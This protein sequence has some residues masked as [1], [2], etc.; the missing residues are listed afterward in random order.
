M[1]TSWAASYMTLYP[2]L[3]DDGRL[4]GCKIELRP[5]APGDDTR[6]LHVTLEHHAYLRICGPL[7]EIQAF[8][9]ALAETVGL[10]E[11]E[12]VAS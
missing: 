8:V 11:R 3:D 10:H 4:D 1:G 5:E 9:R 2:E 6:H 12:A 7:G